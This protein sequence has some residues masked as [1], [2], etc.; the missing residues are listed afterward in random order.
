MIQCLHEQFAMKWVILATL[1][2]HMLRQSFCQQLFKIMPLENVSASVTSSFYEE[3]WQLYS[4]RKSFAFYSGVNIELQSC[5]CENA[6]FNWKKSI[7][8]LRYA[9][10]VMEQYKPKIVCGIIKGHN[11]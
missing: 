4:L 11:Y 1:E 10:F 6:M 3:F 2:S 7:I 9:L 8:C 5:S